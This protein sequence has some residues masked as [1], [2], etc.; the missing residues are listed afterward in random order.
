MSENIR[1]KRGTIK[2]ELCEVLGKYQRQKSKALVLNQ[3]RITKQF[4]EHFR[5]TLAV[6]SDGNRFRLFEKLV[7]ARDSLAKLESGSGINISKIK[8]LNNI[9][10]KCEEF[11]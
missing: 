4:L 11:I 6:Y 2:Q 1:D 8:C 7:S 9:R 3:L 5:Q 10:S